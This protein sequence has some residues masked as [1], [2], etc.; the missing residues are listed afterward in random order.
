MAIEADSLE[1]WAT[2]LLRAWGYSAADGRFLA[3]TLVDANLRGIDS[4]GVL[5]LPAYE[6]RVMAGLVRPDAEPVVSSSGAVVTVDANGAAGQIAARQAADAALT[7]SR[8]TGVAAASVH[9]STH[10]GAAGFYARWL[11]EHRAVGIVVS[12]R[13]SS[14]TADVRRCWERIRSPS[15]RPP[16]AH[17]SAST[18]RPAPVRWAR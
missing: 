18:W 2:A 6:R 12:N 4:H 9:G 17:P 1:F 5:R 13:S 7:L 10:F 16:G 15:P 3:H 11:A 8:S 14:R